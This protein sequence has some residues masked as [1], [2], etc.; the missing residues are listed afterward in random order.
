LRE[1]KPSVCSVVNNPLHD[2][3]L[4]N[5]RPAN[6]RLFTKSR[7]SWYADSKKKT[8][9]SEEQSGAPM[10]EPCDHPAGMETCCNWK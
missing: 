4:S 10:I 1:G 7:G 3:S 9:W 5:I 6:L 8:A 2:R